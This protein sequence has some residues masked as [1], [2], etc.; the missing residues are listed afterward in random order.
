M[1]LKIRVWRGG[2]PPNLPKIDEN[3]DAK[4]A[5]FRDGSDVISH[6][7]WLPHQSPLLF[8]ER[9]FDVVR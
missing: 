9:M 5:F 4:I 8:S 6:A 2:A 1:V 7:P 3:I